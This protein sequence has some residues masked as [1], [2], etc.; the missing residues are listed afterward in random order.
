MRKRSD[1]NNKAPSWN[2]NQPHAMPYFYYY[3]FLKTYHFKVKT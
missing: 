3:H 1:S 2:G